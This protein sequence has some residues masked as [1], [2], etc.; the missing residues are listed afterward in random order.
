MLVG[1]ELMVDAL[2]VLSSVE[3]THQ[4]VL[5]RH[6]LDILLSHALHIFVLHQ[7]ALP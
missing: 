5:I 3:L 6:Y 1:V 4:L 2:E 7:K